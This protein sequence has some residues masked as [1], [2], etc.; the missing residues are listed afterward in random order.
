MI[1]SLEDAVVVASLV[2]DWD[3]GC[4]RVAVRESDSDSVNDHC[5]GVFENVSVFRTVPVSVSE[6][7]CVKE[8]VTSSDRSIVNVSEPFDKVTSNEYVHA[9]VLVQVMVYEYEV[10][11]SKLLDSIAF[12]LPDSKKVSVFVSD[13]PSVE[14]TL[15]VMSE[16]T[17]LVA[18]SLSVL[19][20]VCSSV[21]LA[22][23]EHRVHD[24]VMLSLNVSV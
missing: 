7:V 5:S 1:D 8:L 21:S 20:R 22:V 3:N 9:M 19:V 2:R 17:V 4:V 15:C 18:V 14:E 23:N 12:L 10:D 24:S 16:V 11:T 13:S 6:I